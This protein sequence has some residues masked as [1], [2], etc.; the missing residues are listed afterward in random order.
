MEN[1]LSIEDH[2]VFNL[3]SEPTCF[4]KSI[5]STCIENFLINKKPLFMKARIETIGSMLKYTF[6]KGK[7]NKTF[8]RCFK[9]FD[10]E[11]FEEKLKITSSVRF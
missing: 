5:I 3:I 2:R 11:K 7:P 1:H 8:H 9:K 10:Y 6:A 4:K